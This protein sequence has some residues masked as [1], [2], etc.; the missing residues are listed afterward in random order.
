MYLQFDN[1]LLSIRQEVK[2]LLLDS[3]SLLLL[4]VPDLLLTLLLHHLL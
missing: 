4:L 3:V 1:V 2:G